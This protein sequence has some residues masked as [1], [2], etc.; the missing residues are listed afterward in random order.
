VIGDPHPDF[1]YGISIA[2]NYRNFE[3]ILFGHGVYGNDIFNYV[4]YWTD[5]P[6]MNGNR[7]M[8]VL[9]NS[10]RPENLDA[11]LP[12]L[13]SGDLVSIL[14]S[15]YYVEKGSYFR[16]RNIELAYTFPSYT[17]SKAGLKSVRIFI[18]A[19]NLFTITR[20][21]GLDPEVNLKNYTNGDRQIGVDGG[22]YPAAKQYL[23]GINL[24]L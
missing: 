12:R 5:F 22:V 24:K 19:Q 10:W 7:S 4:K 23:V 14:P 8:R 3:L 1:T 9:K 6:T 13:E 18:Q 16:M 17:L 11:S 20:Y 2:V 21:S 15:T